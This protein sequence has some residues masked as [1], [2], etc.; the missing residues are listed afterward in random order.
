MEK[1]AR[2]ANA[3]AHKHVRGQKRKD[4]RDRRYRER[5]N[6]TPPPAS[7]PQPAPWDQPQEAPDEP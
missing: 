4:R 3:L 5:F 2:E 1:L 6:L 7:P